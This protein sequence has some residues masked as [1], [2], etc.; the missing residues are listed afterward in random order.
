L[1]Y[2]IFRKASPVARYRFVQNLGLHAVYFRQAHI[3]HD[4]L[5]AY[6]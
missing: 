6:Q 1:K 4:P 5:A 2:K 3:K